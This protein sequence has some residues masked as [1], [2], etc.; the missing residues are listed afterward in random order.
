LTLPTA[1][2]LTGIKELIEKYHTV[3]RQ[4]KRLCNE[5]EPS[6]ILA[7]IAPTITTA[8]QRHLEVQWKLLEQT[9]DDLGITPWE[10]AAAKEEVSQF[11]T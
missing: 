1:S 10:E 5:L 2:R 9:H 3:F 11:Q 6:L 4:P 7:S 8:L